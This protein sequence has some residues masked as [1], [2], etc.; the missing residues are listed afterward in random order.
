MRK[1]FIGVIL[2]LACACAQ[3]GKVE[4]AGQ[5]Q[6]LHFKNTAASNELNIGDLIYGNIDVF[7]NITNQK[8]NTMENEIASL[9]SEVNKMKS[10][11]IQNAGYS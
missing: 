11:L 9:K 5:H 3:T 8:F 2:S 7:G 10:F 4:N 1:L 6:I